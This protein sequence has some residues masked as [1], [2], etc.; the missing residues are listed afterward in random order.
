MRAII[1]EPEYLLPTAEPEDL[2]DGMAVAVEGSRI[3]AIDTTDVLRQRW[4][5]ART[6]EL[7][8]CIVMPGLVNAH[9]HGRGISQIQLGYADDF[10][11]LWINSRRARG[12]LDPYPITKLAAACMLENGVT[13]TVH[14]NYSYGSGD[15][16]AEA[17]AT[18]RAY[19]ESGLRVTFCVGAMDRGF[20]VYPPHEAAFLDGLPP[21]LRDWVAVPAGQP[22]AGDGAATV[23]LMERLLVDFGDHPRIRLCYGPAGLQWVSDELLAAL[24]RDAEAKGLGLHIHAAESP[25][26]QATLTTLYPDGA[27]AHMARLGALTPRTALAH[28]VYLDDRDIEAI[29]RHGAVVVRNPG[30]NLRLHNGAAPLAKLLQAGVPV[31]IGTDNSGLADGEDLLGEL[32]LAAGM[33]RLPDWHGPPKP[34]AADLLRMLTTNGAKA[35]Q[36]VPDVGRLAPGARA[37][38]VALSLDRTRQPYLDPDMP[39]IDALLARAAGTDVRLTMVNGEI[40]YHHGAL[41]GLDKPSIAAEAAN[42]ARAARG[43]RAPDDVARMQ[44]LRRH[45]ERHYRETL[46]PADGGSRLERHNDKEG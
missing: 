16:E 36:T 12:S 19:D 35:A 39:L 31:A 38:L 46:L 13:S 17:R 27:F 14:A 2:R 28:G 29:A 21:D 34:G 3:A 4:P 30:S 18:L 8:G 24:A 33:A 37:D 41:T 43:P 25:A 32:R 15:Y 42:A 9:Q 5:D 44:A 45:I 26:Q 6:E 23:N 22:Y 20:V 1:L 11:E 10:L 40:R 7:D